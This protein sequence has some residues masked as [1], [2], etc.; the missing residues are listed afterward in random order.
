MSVQRDEG[1]DGANAGRTEA[2][3]SPRL[4]NHRFD[5]F[6][7]RVWGSRM[8]RLTSEICLQWVAY[9][10]NVVRLLPDGPYR[11][12]PRCYRNKTSPGLAFDTG[13]NCDNS[14]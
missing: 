3:N 14:A 8:P 13:Q 12:L 1:V 6:H 10:R 9:S 7:L 5:L 2:L 4:A 11:F